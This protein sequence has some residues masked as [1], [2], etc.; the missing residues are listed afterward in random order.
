MRV[1]YECEGGINLNEKAFCIV[2]GNASILF[3]QDLAELLDRYKIDNMVYNIRLRISAPESV[4]KFYELTYNVFDLKLYVTAKKTG[5]ETLIKHKA[6]KR[7]YNR[8][9]KW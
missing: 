8:R 5:L 6:E 1:A 9:N 3:L 4:L 2:I 7:H